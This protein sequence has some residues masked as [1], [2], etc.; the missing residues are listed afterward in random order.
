MAPYDPLKHHRHSIRL[1]GYDYARAGAC[2]IPLVTHNRESLF[3]EIENG[4]IR[5]KEAALMLEKWWSELQR[6]FPGVETDEFV[7]MSNHFQGV[8]AIAVGTDLCVCPLDTKG[9]HAGAPLPQIVQWFKTMT[10]NT[11]IQ[12]VKRTGWAPFEGKLWQRNYY[13][14]IIRN[15]DD[16]EHIRKYIADNPFA[17]ESDNENPLKKTDK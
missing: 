9:A 16:L 6:K 15:E 12:G 3:G 1:K 17:W 7:I 4:E 14:H 13:E 8:I 11:Y 10:T 2:F 5:P